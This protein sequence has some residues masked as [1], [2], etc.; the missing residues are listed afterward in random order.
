MAG[1]QL[2]LH[3]GAPPE[4]GHS[5]C[6]KGV[7]LQGSGHLGGGGGGKAQWSRK[8]PAILEGAGEGPSQQRDPTSTPQAGAVGVLSR[9]RAGSWA[10]SGAEG[11]VQGPPDSGSQLPM[12]LPM[13]ARLLREQSRPGLP[14]VPVG[15]VLTP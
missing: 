9:G 6:R 11:A 10:V 2:L 13:G 12:G 5:A 3:T 7:G 1:P 15:R 14:R 8:A 4:A